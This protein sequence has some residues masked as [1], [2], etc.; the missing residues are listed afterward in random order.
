MELQP[1]LVSNTPP[2]R[3][4]TMLAVGIAALLGCATLAAMPFAG[5]RLEG[6][7]P[8]LPAYA[9]GLAVVE[10]MTGVLLLATLTLSRHRAVT[11]VAAGYLFS[12]L[13]AIPWAISFPGVFPA[14]GL[15]VD[16]QSTATLA[17]VRRLGF[18]SSLLAYAALRL[19]DGPESG[20]GQSKGSLLACVFAVA[21]AA[22]AVSV[23]ALSGVG[24]L[25]RFMANTREVAPLWSYVPAAAMTLYVLTAGMLLAARRSVLDLWVTV[26]VFTLAMELFLLSYVAGGTRLTIGWW[27]GRVLGLVSASMVLTVLVSQTAILYARLADTTARDRQDREARLTVMEAL[28]ASIAHEINQPLSSMVT[29]AY[30]ALRWLGKP[31]PHVPEA[32]A[33]L[34]DIVGDGHRAGRIVEETRSIFRKTGGEREL[35]DLPAVLEEALDRL[36]FDVARAG[37]RLAVEPFR[38][39]VIV[40]GNRIQL[41]QVVCNLVTNAL[42]AL[43]G[44]VGRERLVTIRCRREGNWAVISFAD[45]GPG[46][47]QPQASRIFDPFFSTKSNGMGM[48]LMV[49]RTVI[50]AHGGQLWLEP[51]AGAGATFSL[52]LPALDQGRDGGRE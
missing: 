35:L 49:C 17:A 26:V 48:G 38:G 24:K 7:E 16:V 14:L 52:R 10:I 20:R 25:P 37:V 40:S 8:V 42:E 11:V 12:G 15:D 5:V 30:A 3:Q 32:T 47:A 34:Q 22:V 51:D 36:R 19:A 6:T 13:L 9:A 44:I 41:E 4:Q 29:N 45:N 18:A 28:S 2:T 21:A 39:P 27:T 23:L 1:F 50:E 33:A 31:E 43:R 46:V